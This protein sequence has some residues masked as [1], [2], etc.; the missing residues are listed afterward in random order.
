MALKENDRLGAPVFEDE[1]SD[2][3]EGGDESDA[4]PKE[5]FR[6]ECSDLF[7]EIIQ[8]QA[9]KQKTQEEFMRT[10]IMEIR[11]SKLKF[12]VEATDVVEVVFDQII[13]LIGDCETKEQMQQKMKSILGQYKE[14]LKEFCSSEEE[15]NHLIEETEIYCATSKNTKYRSLFHNFLQCYQGFGILPKDIILEWATKAE[16]SLKKETTAED[17]EEEADE[18]LEEVGVEMRTKFLAAMQNYLEKLK[19]ADNES[20]SDSDSSSNSSSSSSSSDD[21][22]E[23]KAA[24]KTKATA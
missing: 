2:L 6:A 22:E 12:A 18:V 4:D 10:L 1:E 24:P 20:G 13:E 9:F 23:K 19:E 11:S 5:E 14:L 3:S 21:S 8:E 15:Q 17:D 16:E 7:S